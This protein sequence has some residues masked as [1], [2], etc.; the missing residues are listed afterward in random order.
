MGSA[1]PHAPARLPSVDR[2]IS[3]IA[4]TSGVR[5]M[6]RISGGVQRRRWMARQCGSVRVSAG[7]DPA[8]LG[9]GR[10]GILPAAQCRDQDFARIRSQQRARPAAPPPPLLFVFQT[11]RSATRQQITH[12]L[13]IR[14]PGAPLPLEQTRCEPAGVGRA[15]RLG[16]VIGARGWWSGRG[17][18]SRRV[19]GVGVA[20]LGS[21][22]C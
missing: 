1:R 7:C 9:S 10:V 13:S 8:V 2:V 3:G 20:L 4:V 21:T 6:G 14:L 15:V 19:T 16:R 22:P 17:D 18:W 5:V 11:L 12:R